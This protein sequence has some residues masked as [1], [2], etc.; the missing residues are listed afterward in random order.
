M[1]GLPGVRA[2]VTK[3]GEA[4][5]ELG[6]RPSQIQDS[7]NLIKFYESWLAVKM[8]CRYVSIQLMGATEVCN[9]TAGGTLNAWAVSS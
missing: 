6:R 9:R 3:F 1:R 7:W 8:E 5:G 2:W 4:R